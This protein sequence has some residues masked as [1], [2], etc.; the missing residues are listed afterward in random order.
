MHPCFSSKRLFCVISVAANL[1]KIVEE[2]HS[3]KNL[4]FKLVSVSLGDAAVC[5]WQ[6]LF[7]C[8]ATRDVFFR[9]LVSRVLTFPMMSNS[10]DSPSSALAK[11][12]LCAGP[13]IAYKCENIPTLPTERHIDILSPLSISQKKPLLPKRKAPVRQHAGVHEIAE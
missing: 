13:L 12:Q 4:T 11:L 9:L 10:W 1:Q 5:R 7:W 3:N 8:N 6:T 2:P